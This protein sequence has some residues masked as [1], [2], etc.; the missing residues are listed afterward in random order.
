MAGI[1]HTLACI[2]GLRALVLDGI[3]LVQQ[4][5][6]SL[7]SIPRG[8]AIASDIYLLI[9]ESARALPEVKDID[10]SESQYLTAAVYSACRDIIIAAAVK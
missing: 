9:Q 3:A 7:A 10:I 5:S 8:F 2:A 6:P 4:G 1:D